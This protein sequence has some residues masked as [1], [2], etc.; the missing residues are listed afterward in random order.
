LTAAIAVAG[1][2]HSIRSRVVIA[3]RFY[4]INRNGRIDGPPEVLECEDDQAALAKT[5]K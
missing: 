5:C 4:K 2:G 1:V 3:Y